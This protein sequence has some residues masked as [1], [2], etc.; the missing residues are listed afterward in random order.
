[1]RKLAFHLCPHLFT[2]EVDNLPVSLTDWDASIAG[3]A[4]DHTSM[5]HH[6]S[7]IANR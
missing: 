2:Y 1:M 7:H 3:Y 5:E 6:V 4:P